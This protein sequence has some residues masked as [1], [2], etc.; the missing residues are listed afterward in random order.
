ME[1]KRRKMRSCSKCGE[2]KPEMEFVKRSTTMNTGT[3]CSCGNA[4]NKRR[5]D[6]D[7]IK[8]R[9]DARVRYWEERGIAEKDMPEKQKYRGEQAFPQPAR[10]TIIQLWLNKEAMIKESPHLEEYYVELNE[11]ISKGLIRGED[12]WYRR[13]CQ[14]CEKTFVGEGKF[15]RRCYA[16]K[17]KKNWRD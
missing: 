6:A 4:A 13:L 12:L 15:N 17:P 16:C 8:A 11:H 5:R 3:C 7:L 10:D 2:R 9:N 1:I 14:K